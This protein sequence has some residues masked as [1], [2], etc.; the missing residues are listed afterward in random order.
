MSATNQ[1]DVFRQVKKSTE[2]LVSKVIQNIFK[3][4]FE[5]QAFKTVF[6]RWYQIREL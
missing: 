5:L 2:K 6:E 3:S 4:T 1:L